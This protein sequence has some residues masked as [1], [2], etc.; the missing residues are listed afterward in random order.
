M[1]TID[2]HAHYIAPELIDALQRD[3]EADG[4]GCHGVTVTADAD[5]RLRLRAGERPGQQGPPPPLPRDITALEPRLAP[6]GLALARWERFSGDF[7]R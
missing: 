4:S 6:L 5:G 1:T 7:G 3:R 2:M